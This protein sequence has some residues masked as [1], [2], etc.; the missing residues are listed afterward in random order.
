M[1]EKISVTLTHYR[2][3]ELL[4]RTISSFLK[5]NKYPVDEFFIID[6]S[7]DDYYN[8]Q[9]KAKYSDVATIII[10]SQNIGQRRSLDIL[11]NSCK[12]DYIFHLEEDWL[13]DTDTPYIE[14][15]MLILKNKLDIHQVHI[16]HRNDNPHPVIGDIQYV[17][18]VGYKFLDSDFRGVWNGFSFNPGLRRKSDLLKMF[19]KGLVEFKD[20]M[21]ASLHTRK[22]N[23]KAVSLENTACRHIGWGVTTQS[24][25]RGF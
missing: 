8:S 24:N 3:L 7:G 9:I 10:N 1:E 23:Y 11:F 22:F 20:E 6:D 13:F 5:T 2:R 16:R 18:G 25:G 15:S 17:Q 4:D 19:P 14:Q 21:Q 12:N